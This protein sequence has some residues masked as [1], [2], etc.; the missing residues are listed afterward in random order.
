MKIYLASN[1]Q[2]NALNFIQGIFRNSL[3]SAYL[4][5]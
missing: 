2:K 4:L 5:I 1:S 3:E